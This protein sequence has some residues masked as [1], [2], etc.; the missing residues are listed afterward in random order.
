LS[1]STTAPN[2]NHD[3]DEDEDED[4]GVLRPP[5]SLGGGVP[6]LLPGLRSS[7]AGAAALLQ[8]RLCHL[9]LLSNLWRAT[10]RSVGAAP[11]ILRWK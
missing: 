9:L 1:C 7:G 2:A 10:R 8:R 3:E 11:V 6:D 4:G 5:P